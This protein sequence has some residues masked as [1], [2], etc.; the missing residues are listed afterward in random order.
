LCPVGRLIQCPGYERGFPGKAHRVTVLGRAPDVYSRGV[1]LLSI[2]GFTWVA[3]VLRVT[4]SGFP[5]V[6][7]RLIPGV[8]VTNLLEHRHPIA[9]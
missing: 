7:P 5:G 3:G 2:P 1:L 8:G 9:A 4:P 6:D